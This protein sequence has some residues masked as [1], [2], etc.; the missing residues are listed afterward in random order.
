[1]TKEEIGG[2]DI[3]AICSEAGMLAFRKGRMK[4]YQADFQI[5]ARRKS[6]KNVFKVINRRR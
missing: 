6:I 1:M 2:A 5:G 3:T 4:M